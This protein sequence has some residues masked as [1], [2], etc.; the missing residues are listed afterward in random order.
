MV[1]VTADAITLLDTENEE[2]QEDVDYQHFE[3]ADAVTV[4]LGE[5][6]GNDVTT[7]TRYFVAASIDT[8]TG[9]FEQAMGAPPRL[10]DARI[11]VSNEDGD[12]GAEVLVIEAEYEEEGG[13]LVETVGT[14]DAL[15]Q[16]DEEY[17]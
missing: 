14:Q 17:L 11:F 7:T 9:D 1:E 10:N 6:A 12:L 15:E 16:F 8:E 4:S 13:E 3:T 5:T 2:V